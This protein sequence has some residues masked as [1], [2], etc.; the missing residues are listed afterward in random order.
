MIRGLRA[1]DAI[2]LTLGRGRANLRETGARTWP[3]APPESR[4]LS[5]IGLARL[6]LLHRGPIP[7]AG[8]AV[9]DGRRHGLIVAR[10]R[11]SGLVWDVEHLKADS[12]EAGVELL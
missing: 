6:A 3:K 5:V 4:D 12:R 2:A 1:S 10:V 8:V 11:A 7:S 9:G